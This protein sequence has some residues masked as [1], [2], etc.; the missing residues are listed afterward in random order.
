[1][2]LKKSKY[3]SDMLF[4]LERL[5]KEVHGQEKD[6]DTMQSLLMEQITLILDREFSTMEIDRHHNIKLKL[7]ELFIKVDQQLDLPWSAAMLA[8]E[9][10]VSEPHLYRLCRNFLADNPMKM[11]CRLRM[12]RAKMLLSRTTES[13]AHVSKSVGYHDPYNFSSTFK[14]NVGMSPRNYRIQN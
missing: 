11:V 3:G 9:I 5:Y 7:Q 4:M 8:D 13:I 2:S 14:K 1:M 10:S 12:N 6:S